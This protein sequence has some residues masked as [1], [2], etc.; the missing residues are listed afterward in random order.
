MFIFGRRLKELRKQANLTQQ[1]LGKMVGVTKVSI[2]CYENGS[3]TPTL[4]TLK[5]LADSL[6]IPLNYLLAVDI[7]AVSEDDKTSTINLAK[8]EIE[9]LKEL[10]MH[11]KLYEKILDDPKRF[12]DYIDKKIR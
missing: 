7:F 9:I 10:R 6:N 1:E 12:I 3:R 5:D 4:D 2:C 8:E 11:P